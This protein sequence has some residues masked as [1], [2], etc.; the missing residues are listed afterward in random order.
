[1]A[2]TR[3]FPVRTWEPMFHVDEEINVEP[4]TVAA[5]Y[6]F[7]GMFKVEKDVPMPSGP[8]TIAMALEDKSHAWLSVR[9]GTPMQ[10]G[11]IYADLVIEK[12]G[13]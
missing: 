4:E 1:M 12:K 11:T 13:L 3:I 2:N 8:A 5:F 7:D 6:V 10:E 9:W